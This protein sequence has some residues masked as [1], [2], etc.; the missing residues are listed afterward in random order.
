MALL[1]PCVPDIEHFV[2]G[3]VEFDGGGGAAEINMKLIN[4]GPR[5]MR[6]DSSENM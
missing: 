1:F 6:R 5:L 2:L 4:V 3:I